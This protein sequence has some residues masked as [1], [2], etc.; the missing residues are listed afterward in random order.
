VMSGAFKTKPGGAGVCGSYLKGTGR[1]RTGRS[2]AASGAPS[3]AR[4]LP[5]NHLAVWRV[6]SGE[7]VAL[8]RVEGAALDRFARA[9]GQLEHEA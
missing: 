7:C 3:G 1:K 9:P 8:E 4:D 2:G 6:Q 5:I